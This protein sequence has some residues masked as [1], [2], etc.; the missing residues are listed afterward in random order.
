MAI[1]HKTP[2]DANRITPREEEIPPILPPQPDNIAGSVTGNNKIQDVG[3]NLWE[4]EAFAQ[5]RALKR[6]VGASPVPPPGD[7]IQQEYGGMFMQPLALKGEIY[8]QE[9]NKKHTEEKTL[10]EKHM[11]QYKAAKTDEEKKEVVMHSELH[12]D[13][14]INN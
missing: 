3:K 12:G 14:S 10:A 8:S 7:G 9:L 1:Y 5:Q 11:E 6:Q 4:G 13:E 2:Q